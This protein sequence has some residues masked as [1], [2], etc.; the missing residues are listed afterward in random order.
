MILV[1]CQGSEPQGLLEEFS[2]V[3]R[4]EI[5]LQRYFAAGGGDCSQAQQDSMG[6]KASFPGAFSV[7]TTT[8]RQP[9]PCTT[10]L[11]IIQTGVVILELYM[12]GVFP[13]G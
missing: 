4:T 10:L 5:R 11:G 13:G 1:D 6:Q 3:L 2:I 8:H 9:R 7:R 12:G